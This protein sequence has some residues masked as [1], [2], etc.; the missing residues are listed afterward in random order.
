MPLFIFSTT[1][2]LRASFVEYFFSSYEYEVSFIQKMPQ[3]RKKNGFLKHSKN[4]NNYKQTS[5]I[6][7]LMGWIKNK[8]GPN[9]LATRSL[10]PTLQNQ[11]KKQAKW[12]SETWSKYIRDTARGRLLCWAIALLQK[13]LPP[14]RRLA[15]KYNI[16]SSKPQG[17]V[18]LKW[19]NV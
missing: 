13:S 9:N 14:K 10:V 2:W 12:G 8:F 6:S 17:C 15:P 3:S 11:G 5:R 7:L 19:N 18:K 1:K 4:N 16:E